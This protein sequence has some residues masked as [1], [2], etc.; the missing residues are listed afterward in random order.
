[1]DA[2]RLAA[3]AWRRKNVSERLLGLSQRVNDYMR[4]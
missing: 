3:G 4:L 2:A 1:M